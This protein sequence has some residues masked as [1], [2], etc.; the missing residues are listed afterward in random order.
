MARKIGDIRHIFNAVHLN[1]EQKHLEWI[2]LQKQ[3]PL[4]FYLYFWSEHY[5]I[6]EFLTTV[7]YTKLYRIPSIRCMARSPVVKNNDNENQLSFFPSYVYDETN[8]PLSLF[9]H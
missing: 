2:D 6:V 1:I 3:T 7:A 8:L 5:K 4:F 9:S